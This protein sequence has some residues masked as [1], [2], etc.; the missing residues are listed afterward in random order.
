VAAASPEHLLAMKVLAARRR[1][2]DDIQMLVRHLG[3][4]SVDEVVAVCGR[5]FPDEPI[6]ARALLI[7]EDLFDPEPQ[8][9][10]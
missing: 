7:L 9:S 4:S 8:S 3:H 6:P 1:D 10:S 2:I 5:V